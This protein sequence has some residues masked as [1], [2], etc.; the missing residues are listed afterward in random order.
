MAWAPQV[1]AL[2]KAARRELDWSNSVV[3]RTLM[4]FITLHMQ[5]RLGG[6]LSNSMSP[7]IA[8]SPTYAVKWWTIK[9]LLKPRQTQHCY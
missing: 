8:Y 9:G 2:L 1:R 4:A 6:G 7:T 5:D 3:D